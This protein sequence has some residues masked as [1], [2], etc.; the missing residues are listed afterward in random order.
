M[1]NSL[2]HNNLLPVETNSLTT[3]TLRVLPKQ[4]NMKKI[5]FIDDSPDMHLIISTI[6]SSTNWNITCAENGSIG[7]NLAKK[8]QPDLIICDINMPELDGYEVLKALRADTNIANI[9]FIFLT[10]ESQPGSRNLAME[11]GADYYLRKPV[12]FGE[13]LELI[14]ILIPHQDD[15]TIN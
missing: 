3:N 2:W 11:L 12:N 14:E 9:P 5:L 1:N 8:I 4:E 13:L 6:F 10:S 15:K 7:L